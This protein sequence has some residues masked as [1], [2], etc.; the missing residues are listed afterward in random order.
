MAETLD[1]SRAVDLRRLIVLSRNGLQAGEEHHG[2]QREQLPDRDASET[3]QGIRTG[4]QEAKLALGQARAVEE[5]IEDAELV[6]EH[7]APD[8][9]GRN[10]GYRPRQD[11]ESARQAPARK[12]AVEHKGG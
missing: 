2:P 7:P 12:L 11:E 10:V 4:D 9:A 1:W 8:Q 5:I 6:V 3:G